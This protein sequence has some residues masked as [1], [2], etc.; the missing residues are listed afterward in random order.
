M[1]IPQPTKLHRCSKASNKVASP[2]PVGDY[3]LH[4]VTAAD[5]KKKKKKEEKKTRVP[6]YGI[7]LT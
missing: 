4:S 7:P 2:D 5:V 6:R 3:L 1:A